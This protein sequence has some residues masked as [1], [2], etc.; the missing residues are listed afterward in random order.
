MNGECK[1]N[2]YDP[3]FG[4]PQFTEE[5]IITDFEFSEPSK[6][7]NLSDSDLTSIVK[8]EF[9]QVSSVPR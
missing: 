6:A 8:I 2:L 5:I 3:K 9:E 7:R 1:F 4:T